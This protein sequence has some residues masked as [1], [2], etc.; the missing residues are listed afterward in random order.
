MAYTAL[1]TTLP[2][3]SRTRQQIVDD[4]RA[5]IQALRDFLTVGGDGSLAW[6]WAV[7]AGTNQKPTTVTLSNGARP[8]TRTELVPDSLPNTAFTM[9]RVPS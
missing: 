4:T 8:V 1:N 6:A 9:R 7:T 5:N 2:L 3:I